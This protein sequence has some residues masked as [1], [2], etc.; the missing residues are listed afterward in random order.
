MNH[1]CADGKPTNDSLHLNKRGK[2]LELRAV[3]AEHVDTMS[4]VIKAMGM[5]VS[6]RK[7][8]KRIGREDE[9]KVC[10][11]RNKGKGK[12]EDGV[13]SERILVDEI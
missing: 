10:R 7:R 6:I 12:Q 1:F 3:C 2:N 5:T 8:K 4:A 9:Q 11:G 13:S